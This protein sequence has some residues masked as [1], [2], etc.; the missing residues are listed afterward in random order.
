MQKCQKEYQFRWLDLEHSHNVSENVFLIFK[1][2][3]KV[4]NK[5]NLRERERERE[6]AHTHTHTHTHTHIIINILYTQLKYIYIYI[7]IYIYTYT[8]TI[9]KFKFLKLYGTIF[10]FVFHFVGCCA[11]ECRIYA[12]T[13]SKSLSSLTPDSPEEVGYRLPALQLPTGSSQRWT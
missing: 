11:D 6:S 2:V 13:H 12:L 8:L 4:H 9:I 3:H 1:E 5:N 10:C 7:Y